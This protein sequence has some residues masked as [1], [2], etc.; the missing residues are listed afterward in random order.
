MKQQPLIQLKNIHVH[1]GGVTALDGVD[2]HL[3]PGEIVV[4]MGPN[5]AGKSTILKSIFG[6][7]KIKSGSIHLHEKLI[8]PIPHE[9]VLKGI[10]FVPQGRRT[11]AHLTV[12]ENLVIGGY[13]LKNKK[14]I[15]ERINEV[16]TLFPL[17]A[18]KRHMACKTLSGGQQQMVA[19][20]RGLMTKPDILLLDEPSLGLA[21]KVVKEVFDVIEKINALQGTAI[22]V[23]EHNLTSLLQIAHRG[24][25]MESGR[26]VMEA[27]ADKLKGSGAIERVLLGVHKS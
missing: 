14:L 15:Q 23:V 5:G 11:F 2:V 1:F 27:P 25:L 13:I 8:H 3:N 22:M 12:E 7:V 10:A 4:L 6:L 20:A 9:M 24:Y 26:L 16:L 19:I 18:H 17:I 21:P